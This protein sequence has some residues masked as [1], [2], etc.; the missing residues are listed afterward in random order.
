M[1]S[2]NNSVKLNLINIM[3][4]IFKVCHIIIFYIYALNIK[5]E[6]TVPFLPPFRPDLEY[7]LVAVVWFFLNLIVDLMYNTLIYFF[8]KKRTTKEEDEEFINENKEVCKEAYLK[9]IKEFLIV[10]MLAGIIMLLIIIYK[11]GH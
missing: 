10:Y 8:K 5:T 1:D 9:I 11:Q 3:I 7:K 4:K 2:I 6:Q